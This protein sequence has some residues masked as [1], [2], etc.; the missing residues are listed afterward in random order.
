[1]T[2]PPPSA[3]AP[4][5]PRRRRLSRLAWT[6]IGGGLVIVLG[7]IWVATG[8]RLT[9]GPAP[10][11][12]PSGADP[13]PASQVASGRHVTPDGDLAF[14]FKGIT[15][16]YAATLAVYSDPAVTGPQ[17]VGTTECIIEL[18]VTDGSDKP[19]AFFDWQQYAYDARGHQLPADPNNA[20]LAGDKDGT[21]L[22][23]GTSITAVVPY[24]IPAGDSITRLEL[25]DSGLSGVPVRL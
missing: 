25:H 24:N 1:M 10:A 4:R 14:Q 13:Q 15:C 21:R 2:T 6:G 11:D 23:P 16:G 19:Q 20:D 3:P 18:R 8:G 7:A 22:R 12:P 9:P 17:Q 5:P